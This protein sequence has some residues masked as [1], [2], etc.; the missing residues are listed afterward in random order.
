MAASRSFPTSDAMRGPARVLASRGWLA[1]GFLVLVSSALLACTHPGSGDQVKKFGIFEQ[2]FT[3]TGTYQNPYVAVTATATF[4]EPGGHIRSIPLFWDGG[5]TWKVRFS[6]DVTGRWSWS[7]TSTD[8]GLAAARGSFECVS[9]SNHGGVM[10]MR[11][12]PYHLQYQ[13]GTPYWLLGDTQWEPFADDPPQGLTHDSMVHYFDLRSS[14]G[15]NY[16]HGE[17]LGQNRA[18]NTGGPAFLSYAAQTLNPAYFQECDVRVIYANTKGMTLGLIPAEED[19]PGPGFQSWMSFPDEAA[20]V[21][22]ARYV[23]AR[24]SAFNVAWIVTTEWEIAFRKGGWVPDPSRNAPIFDRIGQEM[25]NH[26]PHHR[27]IGIH[28]NVGTGESNARWFYGNPYGKWM[29]FADYRQFDGSASP[30]TEATASELRSLHTGML[31]PRS[32][33]PNKPVVNGE[34]A[35]YLRAKDGTHVDRHYSHTRSEFRRAHWVQSMAGS[36]YVTGF[37]ATYYG[38]LANRGAAF[39]PDDPRNVDVISDLKN[40]R[41]FFTAREWWKLAPADALVTASYG[42]C[43]AKVGHTY[44]VYIEQSSTAS[45]SLGGAPAATYSVKRYDTRTGLYTSLANY[46][47]SGPIQLNPPDHQ[48]WVFVVEKS[49]FHRI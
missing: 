35:Y 21:R 42:Y 37:A 18:S 48:D 5:T 29:T 12:Y 16:V 2:A 47:G 7:V 20:R 38:G 13:D 28:D 14:Q 24:Y 17:L 15:F 4:V 45:L 19:H 8:P 3:Q 6:P 30:T 44:L 36:Y 27:L 33:N 34:F 49:R 10:A 46:T 23:V 40:L 41:S 25:A 32:G 22:Y 26:D 11:N 9:S 39:N 1:T 31:D 43:L